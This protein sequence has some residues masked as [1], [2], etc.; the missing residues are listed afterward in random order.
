MTPLHT[1]DQVRTIAR[2]TFDGFL[3]SDLVPQG[4][5]AS[6]LIWVA[7]FFVAPALFLPV[8]AINKYMTIRRF[9]PDRLEEAFWLDRMVFLMMSAGAIGVVSV[10]LWDTLFPARRDAFVLTPLPVP[11]SAQMLGRLAGL[12]GLCLLF[13]V[14]LNAI[15]SVLFPIASS[16]SFAEMPRAMIGHA[17]TTSAADVFVFFS[18]TALQGLVILGLGRRTASR[19]ASFAQAGSV[20]ALLLGLMFIGGVFQLTRDAMMRGSMSDP[21]LQFLPPAWFLGLYEWIAGNPRPI[22]APLAMRAIAATLLP[23][24]ITAAIYAFGYKRLLVRAVETPQRSTRSWLTTAVS[25]AIRTVFIRHPQEQAI[26]S[27]LLRAISRSGRHSMLMSIY[28]GVGLALIASAII[29]DFIRFG[30]GALG[31][32]LTPWPRR[33]NPPL[34]ILMLPVILS[35]ALGVGARILMTIPADMGARW[36]FLIASLTPRRVDAATHKAMVLLVVPPV[37]LLALLTAAPLW[38][39]RVA[40]LHATYTAT[41]SLVLCE[42]LL[43]TFRGVPL[44]RPYV[45]GASRFHMLWALYISG[46]ITYTYTATRLER[47]LLSWGSAQFVMNAAAIFAAM[48]L[49]LWARRKWK[50]RD[51]IDVPYEADMPEDQIFQGFNLSEIQAAQAVASRPHEEAIKRV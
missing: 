21:A 24:A 34:G 2:A 19:I 20:V 26:G 7:A 12:A 51:E 9:F 35:A 11:L 14:A 32:P 31:S 30:N 40:L 3:Q 33:G 46:F 50:L 47:D 4:M 27:F 25:R 22:M 8:K 43:L 6:A 45:P 10:V 48:A 39:W 1:K 49:G 36:I 28:L 17:V 13:V 37:V 23:I 44:T 18:V 5:Q 42:I 41:L 38:G 15:P 16:A 29:P